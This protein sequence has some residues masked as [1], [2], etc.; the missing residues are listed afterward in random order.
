MLTHQELLDAYTEAQTGCISE[1]SG[2]IEGDCRQLR[3]IVRAYATLHGLED[4]FDWSIYIVE[5]D[6]P[7]K[8]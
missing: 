3:D 7:E 5:Q 2:N 1:Y 8:G 6:A 4:R